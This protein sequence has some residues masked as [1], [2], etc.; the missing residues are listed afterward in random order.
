MRGLA[1]FVAKGGEAPG[2]VVAEAMWKLVF[3][4]TAIA[5]IVVIVQ[6]VRCRRAVGSDGTIIFVD[7][8][9]FGHQ[10]P[11]RRGNVCWHGAHSLAGITIGL[12]RGPS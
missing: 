3:L 10:R 1:M 6:Y 9:H 11:S 2:A 5:S 7:G 8:T 4:V 12:S